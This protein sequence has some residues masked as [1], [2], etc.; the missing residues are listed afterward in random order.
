[1]SNFVQRFILKGHP[2]DDHPKYFPWTIAT[3]VVLVGEDDKASAS[4]MLMHILKKE[5][6]IP[7][8]QPHKSTLIESLVYKEGG[9]FLNAY[10]KARNERFCLTAFTDNWIGFK[11]SPPLLF[12]KI[13]EKFIDRVIE[14]A[15]GHRI[16]IQSQNGALPRNA[17][18]LIDGFIF[19]LKII[20]EERLLKS[21]VQNK[22]AEL[23]YKENENYLSISPENIDELNWNTYINLFRQPIQGAIKSA[24][25]Q[26][27]S[28]REFL[29][30]PDLKGGVIVINNGTSSI[31]PE[32]FNECVLKCLENNTK[33]LKS[34]ISINNWVKTDGFNTENIFLIEPHEYLT[35]IQK[36]IVKSFN[37]RINDFMTDWARIGFS[38]SGDILKL[39]RNISFEKHGIVFTKYA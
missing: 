3:I 8:T 36:K 29:N 5:H 15:G 1:M 22:L 21:S 13:S 4:D 17:D 28:T 7:L 33:E 9:Q 24:S 38:Q 19:E 35:D 26:I 18:Y 11:D 37:E 2:S 12:P 16:L 27:K 23:L 14:S 20:E 34:Y 6:W 32:I 30:K 31:T 10:L 25:K 39:I